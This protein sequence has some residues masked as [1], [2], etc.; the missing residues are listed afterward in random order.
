MKPANTNKQGTNEEPP[1][2]NLNNKQQF[3]PN[4]NNIHNIE[5]YEIEPYGT[6]N[7]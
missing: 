4:K 2:L 1:T 7:K 6:Q 3:D 5:S